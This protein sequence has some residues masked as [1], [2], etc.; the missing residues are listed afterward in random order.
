[1]PYIANGIPWHLTLLTLTF[2]NHQY[3]KLRGKQQEIFVTELW[4]SLFCLVFSNYPAVEIATCGW[5]KPL[6]TII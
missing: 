2:S 6:Q 1:M 5:L 4:N 3:L